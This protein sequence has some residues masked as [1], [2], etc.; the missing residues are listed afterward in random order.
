LFERGV[1]LLADNE[2]H[3]A[4]PEAAFK[5]IRTQATRAVAGQLNSP[6]F[7]VDQA[8]HT[9]L[10]P[11]KDPTLRHA[12]PASVKSL[13]LNDIKNYYK[14]AFR[15]DLTTIVVIG[16]IDPTKV[17]KIIGKYF[18]GWQA[19]GTKP[20]VLLPPV[21]TN[22]PAD[23][24]VPNI[25]R[26]QDRVVLAQT[27]DI[28]RSN[29]DYYALELGN[30]VLG[31]AFYATRL[32]RD[33]R[34]ESGLVYYVGVNLQAGETRAV[35]SV[36]FACDPE[37]VS[38]VKYIT[39]HEL[40]DMQQHPVSASELRTAKSLLLR[41]ITLSEASVDTIAQGLIHRSTLDLPLDEPILAAQ[42]YVRLN[43]DQVKAAF[44]KHI[45]PLEWI[46]ITEGPPP[47]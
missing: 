18:G 40:T 43:G 14:K 1:Q 26:V 16:N 23:V 30:H 38:K 44:A 31:G 29:P 15:P 36:D 19:V 32:Y 45:R 22:K 2:L 13:S 37:N 39:Q 3:P 9:G 25:S 41:E 28:T 8:L 20:N 10:F 34:E 12:T 47:R 6:Q 7:L 42:H 35:Y 4:L 17:R 11:G 24:T 27:V 33:L 46:Q 5:I 21:P